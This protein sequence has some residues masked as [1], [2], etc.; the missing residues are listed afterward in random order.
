M[1]LTVSKSSVKLK[2]DYK[3]VI[4]RFFNTGNERSLLLIS[5][6]FLLEDNITDA[7][8]HTIL[9]E[10]SSRY[11]NIQA[12]FLNHFNTIEYLLSDIEKTNL[13][14]SKKLLTGAYFTMEYSI[15][16]A[17]L[18]PSIV[19]DIDQKGAGKDQKK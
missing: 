11:K 10:F 17:A 13:S 5:K 19:E 12:I 16:A 2:P 4:P 7:L 9:S 6:I 8:L 15:E 18:F 14:A 1:A 3:K